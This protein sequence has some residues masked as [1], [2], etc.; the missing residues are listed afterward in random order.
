MYASLPTAKMTPE[1]AVDGGL[2]GVLKD[3]TY[4]YMFIFP[5]GHVQMWNKENPNI[6]DVYAQVVQFDCDHYIAYV[7]N[8]LRPSFKQC[9][10]F[11]SQEWSRP[12]DNP[13]L[14]HPNNAFGYVPR[15]VSGPVFLRKIEKRPQL[16]CKDSETMG[17]SL[18]SVSSP[19]D[20]Y[21][22]E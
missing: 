20:I 3:A 16:I 4:D 6:Y 19:I 15:I 13:F 8:L 17:F 22:M 10:R 18:S 11:P 7:H 21:R 1:Q 2:A 12:F 14:C 5:N 9:V